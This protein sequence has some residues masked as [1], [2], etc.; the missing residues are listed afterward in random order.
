MR[1]LMSIKSLFC[2]EFNKFNNIRAGMLDSSYRMT[3]FTL[4]SHICRKNVIILSLGT[5]RCYGRHKVS[6]KSVND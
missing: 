2:N 5:Q 6:R 3:K 4:K 1:G